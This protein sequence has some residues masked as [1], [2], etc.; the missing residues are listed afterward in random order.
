MF[1]NFF[2]AELVDLGYKSIQEV[3]V[4]RY[5]NQ[6]SVEILQRTFQDIFRLHIQVIGGLIQNKQI[7]RLQQ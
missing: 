1:G 5:N 3:T 6:S 4:V 2:V 7:H